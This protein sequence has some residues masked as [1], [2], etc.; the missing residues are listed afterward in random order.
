MTP[1]THRPVTSHKGGID[2]AKTPKKCRMRHHRPWCQ[3][4]AP[5]R[6]PRW[7]RAAGTAAVVA[8]VNLQKPAIVGHDYVFA[9]RPNHRHISVH[10]R[11]VG[12]LCAKSITGQKQ[13]HETATESL[14]AWPCRSPCRV[15]DQRSI[16]TSLA[17]AA[18][19]SC[20]NRRPLSPPPTSWR[21]VLGTYTVV[22]GEPRHGL[23]SVRSQYLSSRGGRGITTDQPSCIHQR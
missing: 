15:L 9:F 17:S 6:A 2:R 13:I 4:G 22:G 23:A 10:R 7:N 19:S 1:M 5:P 21:R 18:A 3:V 12:L 8:P 20:G 11:Y 14:A 16:R